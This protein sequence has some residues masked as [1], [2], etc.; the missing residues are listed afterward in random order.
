M[1]IIKV[2]LN[3]E[4]YLVAADTGGTF[5]DVAVYDKASGTTS[6]GK[7]LTRYG[8]LV[9]GVLDGLEGTG[10]SLKETALFKHGTT[11]VINTFLQRSGV[12]TALVAT[13]GF[14][15]LV[16]IGRGNRPV[17]FQVNYR[18]DPLLVPRN[19]RYELDERIDSQGK[20]ITPLQ[21][22]YVL[23]L[24]KDLKEAG[25]EA[26]AISF[27]NSYINPIHEEM[28]FRIITDQLPE[29][30]VTRGTELSREW[31]EYERASTAE[32]NAYVGGRMRSY[33]R[34]FDEKLSAEGFKGKLYMMGSNGGV[35]SVERTIA[36]P[37]ALVESGPIGGCI[38]AAAYARALNRSLVIAFDM[39]GTTAKCALVLDGQFDVQPIYYVGGYEHGF[40]LKTPVLDIVE[41][42]TGGGSIAQVGMQGQLTVGPRSAGSEPG[43]IAF[44]RGGLE[45]TVTDANVVLGRIGTGAFVGGKLQLDGAAAASAIDKKIAQPMGYEGSGAT[46][47]AA[48]GILSLACGAMKGAIKEITIERGVDVREF[49]LFAFG[50]G[51]PLFGTA[52]ARDLG[53]P[54][55]IVPPYPGNFSTLGML[56]AGARIDLIRTYRAEINEISML[57]VDSA[58]QELENEARAMM[59]EDLGAVSIDFEYSLELRYQGQNHTVRTPYSKGSGE[60]SLLQAFSK[61]YLARYGH[62]NERCEPEIVG[63]G[64]GARADVPSP[65]LENLAAAGATETPSPSSRRS[66]YF[67]L[68]CGRC[69]TDVWTRSELPVGFEVFGPAIIEEFSSTCVL[70]PGDK[71]TV[72]SLGEIIIDCTAKH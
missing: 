41:V 7:T 26:V 16:E 63:L 71:A 50:G 1:Q 40:P 20:I 13:K 23:S 65:G 70:M 48:Q 24:C 64:L 30:Y 4:R 6:Y 29:M 11:H 47:I 49:S 15:D 43:P 62:I 68:P 12:K 35:M 46:D 60:D 38:G 21:E 5:T 51:G 10:V 36:Q 9:E 58:F 59:A 32:A 34:K 8:E 61:T 31:Y 57:Q 33:L 19:Q 17:P 54:E 72:G 3:N 52:L 14:K 66:V 18:R 2:P 53:I 44:G 22:S 42:G 56:M 67:P 55:V 69:E 37:V 28:A 39:G 45:P 27:L 25:I